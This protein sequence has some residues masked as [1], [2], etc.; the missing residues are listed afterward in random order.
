MERILYT[1][2]ASTFEDVC[3]NCRM[4]ELM[5]SFSRFSEVNPARSRIRVVAMDH[6]DAMPVTCLQ[7]E[8]APCAAVCPV[9]AI[10]RQE[11]Q[12]LFV[13]ESRCIGCG[14]CVIA[15]PVGAITIDPL[16]GYA[17]K[18]DLCRGDP[19]CVKYCP[20]GVLKRGTA[21][22]L[23]ALKSRRFVKELSKAV[24]REEKGP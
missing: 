20:P 23:A 4:C 5:C 21:S 14:I 17:S 3:S 18:C 13:D 24:P 15:C 1:G 12:Y 7:C 9:H 16:G 11:D 6:E 19:Q 22:D 8:D 10:E 2:D